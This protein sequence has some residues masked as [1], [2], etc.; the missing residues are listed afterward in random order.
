MQRR[1]SPVKQFF[2]KGFKFIAFEEALLT[3]NPPPLC[4]AADVDADGVA[5]FGSF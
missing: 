5:L 3:N 2:R 1:Y 4:F